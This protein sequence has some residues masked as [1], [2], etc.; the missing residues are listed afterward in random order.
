MPQFDISSF[1]SQLFWLGL[2]FS[3]L[4]FIVSKV[5]VP[6]A[7]QILSSRDKWI[8]DNLELAKKYN[9]QARLL[10]M[11]N[12]D[13]LTKLNKDIESARKEALDAQELEFKKKK[14]ELADEIRNK[15]KE[16]LKEIDDY[17]NSFQNDVE[18]IR[19][20]LSAF[21]IEKITG[22]TANIKLLEKIEKE[23]NDSNI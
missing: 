13:A 3:V 5:I 1:T 11:S 17:K 18:K 14:E 12:K 8:D 23:K 6:K 9:E 7:E 20:N 15:Q 4:Y 2:V 10:E 22:K 19:I 21:I 16:S